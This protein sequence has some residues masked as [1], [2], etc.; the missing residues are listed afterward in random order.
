MSEDLTAP[1]TGAETTVVVQTDADAPQPNG[2]G[3]EAGAEGAEAEP[4]GE[5]QQPEGKGK[6]R[7]SVRFS[8]LTGQRDAEKARADLE[9]QEKDYWKQQALAQ[10][11]ADTSRDGEQDEPVQLTQAQLDAMLERKLVEREQR[12]AQEAAQ[13]SHNEKVES[14]RAKL[15]DSGLG[16]A[17]TAATGNGIRVTGAMI[18]VLAANDQAAQIVDHLARNPVEAN[19]IADLPPELVGY[20]LAGLT[21]R[22]ASQPKTTN[23]PEPPSTVGARGVAATGLRDDLPIDDW[24][25]IDAERSAKRR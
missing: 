11:A 15:F 1:E 9:A 8:E 12:A 14:F 21:A 2:E 4:A 23:A 20:E 10:Q 6:E 22:L 7:L 25:R 13:R 19:R 24:M 17:V 16:G 18:N 3:Q 5:Q